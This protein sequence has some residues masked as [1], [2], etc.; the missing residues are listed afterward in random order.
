MKRSLTTRLMQVAGTGA[1]ALLL[2]GCATMGPAGA[3]QRET[4]LDEYVEM[5]DGTYRYEAVN[6]IQGEGYTAHVIDLV[7][8]N[9]RSPEEVDRTEWRHWLTVVVPD[10]VQSD[11][12]LL[13]ITGGRNGRPA[14]DSVPAEMA[15]MAVASRSVVA[16]LKQVPNQP[17]TFAGEDEGRYEDALIAYTWDKHLRGGDDFW[18]ARL[19]MTKAAVRAMDTVQDYLAWLPGDQQVDVT[20]F[21]VAGAS[22]RGWTTWTTAAVD[23]RV[24]GI[25]PIVIDVLNVVES[26]IHHHAAYGFWAPAVGDYEREGTMEWMD[27]PEMADLMDIVDP[28]AYIERYTMPKLIL[29]SAGDQFF[30]PDSSQFYF[31]ALP[32]E[33]HLRYVP[34]TGHGLD[35]SDALQTVLAFHTAVIYGLQ[36]PAVEWSF[37]DAN[38]IVVGSE[39][40][41]VAAKLW[42]ATNVE[43]RDFRIDELGAAWTGSDLTMDGDGTFTARVQTPEQGWTGFFIELMFDIGAPTPLKLTTPVRVVPDTLPYEGA[44]AA[45]LE[46]QRLAR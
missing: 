36:R 7:S 26:M 46:E 41:P 44:W 20:G 45:H 29:N 14:P 16:E 8:Q 23:D 19:P 34:N 38:T 9:W 18:P 6:R 17:I 27:T 40:R 1:A 10:E 28:Y 32:G 3:P 35:D 5:A 13:Y 4:A 43:A 37:P 12:A 15:Q 22:K 30:L 39:P 33:R 31:R 2:A 24:V 11:K 21:V 42:T 25:V